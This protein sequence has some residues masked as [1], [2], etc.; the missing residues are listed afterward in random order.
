MIKVEWDGKKERKKD[1]KKVKV[2][3]K[4]V[5]NEYKGKEIIEI[6]KERMEKEGKGM[7]IN[8]REVI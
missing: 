5:M 6:R 7:E 4:K 1:G 3:E 8:V 2:K